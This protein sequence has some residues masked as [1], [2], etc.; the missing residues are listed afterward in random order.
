[1]STPRVV[2]LVGA[3]A[4]GKTDLSIE[5]ARAAGVPVEI[6]ILDSRQLYRG[7]DV[8]TGKPDAQQRAA[9][10]HHLLDVLEPTETPDAA[11]Y[12]GECERVFGEIW[13]RGASVL[14]VGGAG[15]Y[16]RALTEGFHELES[17]PVRLAQ[18][19]AE[20]EA[21]D[22]ASLRDRL[23]EVDPES[24]T[25]LHPNDRY[26]IG[27]ALE[28]YR[29]SGR[30]A[31]EL[32]RNFVPRPVCDARFD[33][34]Q[35]QVERG[36]LHER[37]ETRTRAWLDGEAWSHEIRGLLATGVPTDAPGLNILGYREVLEAMER[38]EAAIETLDA[39]VVATRRYARQQETWLRKVA[40]VHRGPA[41]EAHRNLLAEALRAASP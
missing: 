36:V 9:I 13:S 22:D 25:R 16:L 27:R 21:L 10:P 26:R 18:V 14:L 32:E 30:P 39:I 37:I 34:F 24:A 38:G 3:T 8:G 29:L 23:A 7:L 1:M 6:V 12:R 33:V 15:F 40:A 5:A 28:L 41:D 31:S 20:H 17:D 4:S 19:R 35:L 2:A 11:W